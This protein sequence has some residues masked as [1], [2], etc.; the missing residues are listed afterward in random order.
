MA[1]R[2]GRPEDRRRRDDRMGIILISLAILVATFVGIV[3]YATREP[4]RNSENGC[5]IGEHTAPPARTFILVD[6][7][8]ALSRKEL[9]FARDLIR[10][11]YF[12]LPINGVL[13]IRTITGSVDDNADAMTVCRVKVGSEGNGIT[14][15][16]AALDK[17]FRS[18]VGDRLTKFLDALQNAP[19]QQASPI[20][21]SVDELYQR[22][23]FGRDIKLRRV[24]VLSDMAQYSGLYSQYGRKP[25]HR[26]QVPEA[27]V[28][29]Y[30]PDMTGS[31]IRLQYV[32]RSSI[33]FQGN[34]HKAF[35]QH[36]FE[37]LGADVAIGHALDLGEPAG[38]AIWHDDSR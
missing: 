4:K 21:E 17:Q 1:N 27:L 33:P 20:A 36:Y 26:Y 24:V 15:N 25:A 18:M 23:D 28:E 19:T 38:R 30:A 13:T 10:N 32:K 29:Q 3:V 35:W 16:A 14:N 2:Y 8:D 37:H 9:D 12:W 31:A 5:P 11:E 22:T 7:T 6:Q 34:A